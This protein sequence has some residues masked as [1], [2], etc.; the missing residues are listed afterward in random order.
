MDKNSTTYVYLL[1]N[2]TMCMQLQ[3]ATT[4]DAILGLKLV[5]VISF[6][7]S[8]DKIAQNKVSLCPKFMNKS[9]FT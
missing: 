9:R 5:V 1:T 6:I 7:R 2:N 8:I 3:C 4:R